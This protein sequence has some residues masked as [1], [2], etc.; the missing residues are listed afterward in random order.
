MF[1]RCASVLAVIHM[2]RGSIPFDERVDLDSLPDQLACALRLVRAKN[3]IVT[4]DRVSFTSGTFITNWNVLAPF[5]NGELIV[6][7]I[8]KRLEYKVSSQQ[9]VI[10]LITLSVSSVFAMISAKFPPDMIVGFP[11]MIWLVHVGSN[12]LIVRPRFE[13]FLRETIDAAAVRAGK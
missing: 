8:N 5:D 4:T 13:I 3:V 10:S 12:M 1:D 9:L 2:N 7:R 6:D 11:V